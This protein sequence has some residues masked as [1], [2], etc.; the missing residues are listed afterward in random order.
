MK[1]KMMFY[2]K[3]TFTSSKLRDP[4]RSMFQQIEAVARKTIP[5][6]YVVFSFTNSISNLLE[7]S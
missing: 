3:R 6:H 4:P 1:L 2:V 7:I 5:T